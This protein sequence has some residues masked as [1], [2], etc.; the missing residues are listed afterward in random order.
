MIQRQTNPTKRKP[1]KFIRRTN[2]LYQQL[3]SDKRIKHCRFSQFNLRQ[4][5][6]AKATLGSLKYPIHNNEHKWRLLLSAKRNLAR[7]NRLTNEE[8]L[9]YLLS[10]FRDQSARCLQHFAVSA[11][12]NSASHG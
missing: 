8:V 1:N 12:H 5:T 11:Y 3:T 9:Q 2:T 4:T 6:G 7:N 10:P